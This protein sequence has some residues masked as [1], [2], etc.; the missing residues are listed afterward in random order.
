VIVV[1][2]SVWVAWLV[3]TDAHH[4]ASRSWI[5]RWLRRGGTVAIPQLAVVEVAGAIARRSGVAALGRR[6]ATTI[7][8]LPALRPYPLDEAAFA[9]ATALAAEHRLRGA[10]A[11]YVALARELAVPLLSWDAE[12]LAR[13]GTVVTSMRPMDDPAITRSDASPPLD[14]QA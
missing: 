9:S 4:A 6:A 3:A 7:M 1:D 2:A 5:R 12:Q 11:V 13:A 14:P 8:A 10:D